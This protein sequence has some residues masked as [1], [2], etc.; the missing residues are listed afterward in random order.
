M[1]SCGC[2]R[3][4]AIAQTTLSAGKLC[5]AL[6]DVPF[7]LFSAYCVSSKRLHFIKV[8]FYEVMLCYVMLGYVM[9][10]YVCVA[11]MP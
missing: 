1:R 2:R 5:L 10:C 11:R 3:A 8:T 6:S 4:S 7:L 9:L